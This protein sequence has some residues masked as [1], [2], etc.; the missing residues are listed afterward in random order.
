MSKKPE[1]KLAAPYV[2]R[3]LR[4]P[5]IRRCSLLRSHVEQDGM[6]LDLSLNGAYIT[7]DALPKEGESIKVSFSVPGNDR[8]LSMS[9]VVA[10][11]NPHQA[12]PVHSLPPGF[13]LCFLDP[14]REDAFLITKTIQDYCR[15]NP[16]YRQYL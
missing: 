14:A 7:S 2:P 16:V 4:I 8:I 9:A 3:T 12:H 6:I 15:S 13:G 10:W 5:F 1:K 11:L